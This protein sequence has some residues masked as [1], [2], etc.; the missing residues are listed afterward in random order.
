M[1]V[2]K[3]SA[4]DDSKT[5]S[6]AKKTRVAKVK[7][8]PKTNT[9]KAKK[10]P[11]TPLSERDLYPPLVPFVKLGGYFKGAWRELREVRWPNRKATWSLTIAVIGFSVFF[12]AVILLLD[13]GYKVLFEQILR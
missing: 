5:E 1:A 12:G 13:A 3:I 6:T 4:N 2:T 10:A 9:P 8:S 11:K 7:T